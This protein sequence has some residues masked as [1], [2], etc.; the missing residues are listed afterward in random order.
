MCCMSRCAGLRTY[1]CMCVC[2]GV[3]VRVS[4]EGVRV[5][6]GC[7]VLTKAYVTQSNHQRIFSSNRLKLTRSS[8]APKCHGGNRPCLDLPRSGSCKFYRSADVF[9]LFLFFFFFFFFF[10]FN[11][12]YCRTCLFCSDFIKIRGSHFTAACVIPKKF[13]CGSF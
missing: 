7:G 12:F 9:F 3:C 13:N 11:P 8:T 6:R 10:F 1:L 4:R 5:L 2:L